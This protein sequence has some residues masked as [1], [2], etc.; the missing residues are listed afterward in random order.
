MEAEPGFWHDM[1][2]G[3]GTLT[4][5]YPSIFELSIL[6]GGGSFLVQHPSQP[7]L[8]LQ[9]RK[10]LQDNETMELNDLI[11]RFFQFHFSQQA[12]CAP[13]GDGYGRKIG[14][15]LF[16]YSSSSFK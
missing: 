2:T 1:S 4:E 11:W 14:A 7:V 8:N 16:G 10:S 5:A 9:L 6:K 15:S 3:R 12:R 13:S